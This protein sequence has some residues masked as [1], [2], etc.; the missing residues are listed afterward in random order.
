MDPFHGIEVGAE[1][2][3]ND[4]SL[5]MDDHTSI[6]LEN[7]RD[8]PLWQHLHYSD[9]S[10]SD[11]SLD[12][13]YVDST[14]SVVKTLEIPSRIPEFR[15]Q[16]VENKKREKNRNVLST[17]INIQPGAFCINGE[18]RDDH[19]FVL[20]NGYSKNLQEQAFQLAPHFEEL[21]IPCTEV[22]SDSGQLQPNSAEVYTETTFCY[23]EDPSL[24]RYN[25]SDARTQC[26]KTINALGRNHKCER[27]GRQ[28]SRLYNLDNHVCIEKAFRCPQQNGNNVETMNRLEKMCAEA[29]K[30]LHCLQGQYK[31]EDVS[32]QSGSSEA[33]T[34]NQES[35][36]ES[37]IPATFP[38]DPHECESSSISTREFHISCNDN[39]ENAASQNV[40]TLKNVVVVDMTNCSPT[41][42]DANQEQDSAKQVEGIDPQLDQINSEWTH[43]NRHLSFQTSDE[44]PDDTTP[45]DTNSYKCQECG[46]IYNSTCSFI[47]HLHWHQNKD[48]SSMVNAE[49]SLGG[50]ESDGTTHHVDTTLLSPQMGNC[51]KPAETF[52]FEYCGKVFNSQVVDATNTVWHLKK[53]GPVTVFSTQGANQETGQVSSFTTNEQKSDACTSS[54]VDI[55]TCQYCGRVFNKLCAY[56]NHSRWHVKEKELRNKFN[57]ESTRVLVDSEHLKEGDTKNTLNQDNVTFD[58][59]P[60]T[61]VTDVCLDDGNVQGYCRLVRQL[62][63]DE[64][65]NLPS[66]EQVVKSEESSRPP[67]PMKMET[68]PQTLPEV[69]ESVLELVV[70]TE[71][72]HEILLSKAGLVFRKAENY[73][74]DDEEVEDKDGYEVSGMHSEPEENQ[75][76]GTKLELAANWT[77]EIKSEPAENQVPGMEL[78]PAE[79]Q[80]PRIEL[81]PAEYQVPGMKLEPA[82]NQVPEMKLEPAENQ[83]PKIKLEPAE[84]QVPGMELEP[85]ENLVPGMK[86]EPAENQVPGMELEPAENQVPGMELEPAENQVPGM[87]LEPTENQVPQME[88]EPAENQVP[89]MELEPAE[90]QVPRMELEPAENQVPGMKLEPAENQVPRMELE[91]TKN[92]IP[93]TWLKPEK[94]QIPGRQLEPEKKIYSPK[95]LPSKIA[96]QLLSRPKPPHRC[97]DCGIRFHQIW[98][99]KQHR[100]K[101]F[102]KTCTLKKHQCDCGRTPIGSLHFLLHQLQHLSDTTF[103]C[104]VCNKSLCGYRQLQAH[105]LIHP[106]V[107]QFQCKC[108]SR[109]TKLPRY[110]WHSL[111]NKAK[112]KPKL[113][114]GACTEPS[115]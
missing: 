53:E 58:V 36:S 94:T 25:C 88:L 18:Q 46:K 114:M 41:F 3:L 78:E 92:P 33:Q 74:N 89:R 103:T 22:I 82:E 60:N 6:K 99:L 59:D 101:G 76:C 69:L 19:Y 7:K 1:V 102:G 80:V 26:N 70:G 115:L 35:L 28:F 100:L 71:E 75:I 98:Q 5:A 84:N 2:E 11:E 24:G 42:P 38:C 34:W 57:A 10:S 61:G 9:D 97:R 43:W 107:S 68:K 12:Q 79:N 113:Q 23:E 87:V 48:I 93:G 8:L 44:N 27:C 47:N 108:G 50:Q 16:V 104:A 77:P 40:T 17:R 14:S 96:A 30:E 83:F 67:L 56:T 4:G 31:K 95:I 15:S 109:F 21:G 54:V 81:E 86:L 65:H 39:G 49:P 90:N 91:P 55:L 63:L 73:E 52:T 20:S 32:T 45:E 62:S 85:A 112:P 106:L 37:D 13:Q 64:Q 51:A 110:L 105:S 29:Q 111:K 72:V 66:C